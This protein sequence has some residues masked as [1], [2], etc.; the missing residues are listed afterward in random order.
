MSRF[1]LLLTL[2]SACCSD[3]DRDA[4][5]RAPHRSLQTWLDTWLEARECIVGNAPDTLTGVTIGRLIGRDCSRLLH[6]LEL[7]VVTDDGEVDRAWWGVIEHLK[8]TTEAESLATRANGI[9]ETDVA[10]RALGLAVGRWIPEMTKGTPLPLLPEPMPMFGGVDVFDLHLN[11]GFPY[12]Y[13]VPPDGSNTMAI[14][15]DRLGNRLSYSQSIDSRRPIAFAEVL[16]ATQS[17]RVWTRADAP[18]AYAIDV[19]PTGGVTRTTYLPGKLRYQAQHAQTGQIVMH[20]EHDHEYFIHRIDP[21]SSTPEISPGQH[22]GEHQYNARCMH[23]GELWGLAGDVAVHVTEKEHWPKVV[24]EI[25]KNMTLDC[26][27]DSAIVLRHHPDVV[28]RCGEGGCAEVFVAPTNL[29]GVA[30]FLDD[31]RWIYSAVHGDIVALWVEDREP[32]FARMRRPKNLVAITVDRGLP[33]LVLRNRDRYWSVGLQGL[34]PSAHMAAR[35]RSAT[36]P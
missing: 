6:Q 5:G 13:Q 25:S 12:A 9:D 32:T 26:R 14:G 4:G 30:A 11:G 1:L 23:D 36:Q 22:L 17:L 20:V 16:T 24:Y 34:P 21:G 3:S 29:E 28:E 31:G 10:A 2:L 15:V 8:R 27:A 7:Q 19:T 18:F 33:I 35:D